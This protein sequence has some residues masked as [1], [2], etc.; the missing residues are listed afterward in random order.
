[1]DRLQAF[2]NDVTARNQVRLVSPLKREEVERKLKDEVDSGWV[3][4][5]TKPVI[6][7]VGEGRLRL[8]W[9]IGYRN[10]FQTFLFGTLSDD[11]RGTR[12]N[13]RVGM[14]PLVALFMA[15][16]LGA[17]AI[18]AA[19]VLALA[20]D[21]SAEGVAIPLVAAIVPVFLLALGVLM[22]WAGRSFARDEKQRLITFLERTVGAKEA[23]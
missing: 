16:W 7:H 4:F 17:V 5:A 14:H 15:V 20:S 2:W 13:C 12:L 1:M 9:R 21:S 10:S 22:V 11:G 8:R 18:G 6:G 19:S 3:V 23:H